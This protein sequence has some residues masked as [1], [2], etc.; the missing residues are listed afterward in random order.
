MKFLV[1]E[2]NLRLSTLVSA[3]LRDAGHAVDAAISAE[4]ARHYLAA[5]PYDLVI[6]DLGLPDQDGA[7]LLREL[8][9][10]RQAPPILVATARGALND[11][12]QGLELGADDYLVKPFHVSELLARCRAILR[13]PGAPLG[14]E[15]NAG[16]ILID[17]NSRELRIAGKLIAMPPKEL[18]ALILMMRRAGRVVAR[19]AFD[20]AVGDNRRDVGA[21]AMEAIISRLRRRLAEANSSVKIVTVR[22]IGYMLKDRP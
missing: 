9:A 5:S 17:A 13:R 2:D 21:N 6:L 18:D 12:I 11:R 19:E 7:Q 10:R 8:R 14:Q 3:S 20:E 4:E 16:D 15:L 22:G 1:V